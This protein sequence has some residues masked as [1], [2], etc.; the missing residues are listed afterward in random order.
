MTSNQHSFI[1]NG[2]ENGL[3]IMGLTW[4]SVNEKRTGTRTHEGLLSVTQSISL[5]SSQ[6]SLRQ[7]LHIFP[8]CF[9]L[10]L[11][12]SLC[13]WSSEWPCASSAIAL[14]I[15]PSLSLGPHPWLPLPAVCLCLPCFTLHPWWATC[16][17]LHN[18]WVSI[19]QQGSWCSSLTVKVQVAYL[20]NIEEKSYL[21]YYFC[22]VALLITEL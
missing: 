3:F 14:S 1:V 21:V 7:E 10:S 9:S 5:L 19:C 17:L 2:D 8:L 18:V 12:F 4:Y 13:L 15:S 20:K 6:F 22:L 16:S 11:I